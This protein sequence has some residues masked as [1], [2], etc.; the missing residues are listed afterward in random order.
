MDFLRGVAILLVIAFHATTLLSRIDMPPPVW[1]EEA[2]SFFG[3]YRMPTLMFLSG[4]LLPQSLKKDTRTYFAGK[5]R[6]V[7]WP[8]LVWS[9]ITALVFSRDVSSVK[10]IIS[11]LNAGSYLWFL[12][13]IGLFYG[14]AYFVKRINP[15]VI[16]VAAFMAGAAALFASKGIQVQSRMFYLMSYFFLGAYVA[17]HWVAFLAFV[18]KRT[19]LF[20][21]LIA[22]LGGIASAYF[23]LKSRPVAAPLVFAF[24]IGACYLSR[25]VADKPWAQLPNFVGQN[26]LKFYV[27][28]F[29]AIYL[30]D[31]AAARLGVQNSGLIAVSSIIVAFAVG[32]LL[33]LGSERSALIQLLFA[34]PKF[35]GPKFRRPP[36]A[37]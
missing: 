34:A 4:L 26:S 30:F 27:S 11:L 28:H 36:A 1:L 8:Y 16:A 7:L 29:P 10:A 37:I 18:D 6:S 24:I 25:K 33:S 15:L 17:R 9:G 5:M 3:L 31:I 13:F 32:M 35:D 23:D 19:S 20:A 14:F 22:V 2:T 21:V 12:F